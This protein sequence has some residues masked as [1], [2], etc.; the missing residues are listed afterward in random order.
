[1][2]VRTDRELLTAIADG[3][4]GAFRELH[5]R[6]VVWITLRLRRRCA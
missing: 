6:N 2:A 5:D 4:R 1:M 3:D